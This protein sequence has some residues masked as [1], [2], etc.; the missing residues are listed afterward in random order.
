MKKM[1]QPTDERDMLEA[2]G[3]PQYIQQLAGVIQPACNN[4]NNLTQLVS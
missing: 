1:I 3:S 2:R 4:L